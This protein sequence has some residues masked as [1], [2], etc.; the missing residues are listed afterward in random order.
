MIHE[1]KIW[2]TFYS[3]VKSGVK[4]FEVRKNDR[5][6]QSGDTV[7]LK[8]FDPSVGM[9]GAYTESEPLEFTVGFLLPIDDERVV[10]SLLQRDI[11]IVRGV[12]YPIAPRE[13]ST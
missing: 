3:R 11:T 8:E 2:P 7:I 13:A 10:F 6:F 12:I 9:S 5:G 4:T 1:L